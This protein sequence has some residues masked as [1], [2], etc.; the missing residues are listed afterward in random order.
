M[1][2]LRDNELLCYKFVSQLT[3]YLERETLFP[4]GSVDCVSELTKS[5]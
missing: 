2:E 1:V 4:A 5:T 3:T